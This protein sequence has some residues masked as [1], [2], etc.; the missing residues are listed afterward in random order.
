M[1]NNIS[2]TIPLSI[3]AK[4][5][6][7]HLNKPIVMGILN[8]TDDSFYSKTAKAAIASG[9]AIINDISAGTIDKEM[10]STIAS[11]NVPYV[12]MHM[13]GLPEYM[14]N[15]PQYNDVVHDTINYFIERVGL[16][17]Q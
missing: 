11:L 13:Q 4:G 15:A 7:I 16:A 3:N 9:A 1:I 2:E 17:R 14:Q 12:M 10:L 6:L 8:I 5:N